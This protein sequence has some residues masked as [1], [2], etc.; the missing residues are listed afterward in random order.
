[1]FDTAIPAALAARPGLYKAT[2]VFSSFE[3]WATQAAGGIVNQVHYMLGFADHQREIR[4]NG[5][6]VQPRSSDDTYYLIGVHLA[7]PS[8]SIVAAT[9]IWANIQAQLMSPGEE[10]RVYFK[11]G[12]KAKLPS[13]QRNDE[14]FW[15]AMVVEVPESWKAATDGHL[16]LALKVHRP[17]VINDERGKEWAELRVTPINSNQGDRPVRGEMTPVYLGFLPGEE[18]ARRELAGIRRIQ[19]FEEK[20]AVP[21]GDD[22][23]ED[24]D[25]SDIDS[26][27]YDE[28]EAVIY[29][30]E[31]AARIQ[32]AQH[33]LDNQ[34]QRDIFQGAGFTRSAFLHDWALGM[35][36]DQTG[37]RFLSLLH[38]DYRQIVPN[39]FRRVPMG[40]A[41]IF[42]PAGCTKSSVLVIVGLLKV[43]AGEVVSAAA[44]SNM[45]ATN[46][47]N[48]A[49]AFLQK[50]R[51]T[52]PL[53]VRAYP[54]QL[55]LQAVLSILHLEQDPPRAHTTC[56]VM[57]SMMNSA[58]RQT[59]EE[60]GISTTRALTE[61]SLSLPTTLQELATLT[62]R[63]CAPTT[64]SWEAF[65]MNSERL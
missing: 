53:V 61:Y 57:A 17:P 41:T 24:E 31:T 39:Y 40:F 8:A 50:I 6:F 37:A 51:W 64:P 58:V 30:P 65:S 27:D 43:A 20:K 33:S 19:P 23:G 2:A 35:R 5:Y 10:V 15:K 52:S 56:C 29:D 45:A 34:L 7:R 44:P 14:F 26:D 47:A 16:N 28:D 25:V 49:C 1:M 4:L 12:G 48:K 46:L 3:A 32:L 22:T 36:S 62:S 60:S 54:V 11:P 13:R 55:E 38:P 59:A 42:G 9:E 21:R 63:D 18:V